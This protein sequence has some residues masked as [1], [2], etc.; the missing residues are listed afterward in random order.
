MTPER[1]VA[2]CRRMDD[3]K[4]AG[5]ALRYEPKDHERHVSTIRNVCEVEIG[6]C[7]R[8]RRPEEESSKIGK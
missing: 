4:L 1:I 5:R 3:C 2:H 7:L 8:L 6:L